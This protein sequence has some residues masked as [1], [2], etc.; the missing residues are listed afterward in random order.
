MMPAH[1]SQRIDADQSLVSADGAVDYNGPFNYRCHN[2][3]LRIQAL[4]AAEEIAEDADRYE[5]VTCVM[6]RQV[7]LMNPWTGKVLSEDH[8]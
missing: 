6:C 8:N 1:D 4:A 5:P 7:H 2:T 3:G